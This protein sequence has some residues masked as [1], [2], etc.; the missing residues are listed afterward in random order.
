[1][2]SYV[3]MDGSYECVVICSWH[4]FQDDEITKHYSVID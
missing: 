1:M 4:S 2:L 3:V